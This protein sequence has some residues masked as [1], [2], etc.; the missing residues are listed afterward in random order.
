[1]CELLAE[2]Y[3][4]QGSFLSAGEKKRRNWRINNNIDTEQGTDEVY[5]DAFWHGHQQYYHRL[6][7]CTNLLVRTAQD[8]R[9]TEHIPDTSVKDPTVAVSIYGGAIW[10]FTVKRVHPCFTQSVTITDRGFTRR[11]GSHTRIDFLD[12]RSTGC[13]ALEQRSWTNRTHT[14]LWQSN[15]VPARGR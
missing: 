2:P 12:L 4:N 10:W 13:C 7:N 5:S 14:C 6:C 3:K 9:S 1:M 15:F 11:T 8:E